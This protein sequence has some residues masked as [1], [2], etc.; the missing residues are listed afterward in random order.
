MFF[1]TLDIILS[2]FRSIFS[3]SSYNRNFLRS[4]AKDVMGAKAVMG[5]MS[6]DVLGGGAMDG[7]AMDR[8]AMNRGAMSVAWHGNPGV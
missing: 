7:G 2:I 8:G 1:H 6:L 5:A 4:G 3:L